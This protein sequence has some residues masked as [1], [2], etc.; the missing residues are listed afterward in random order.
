[1]TIK[2]LKDLNI[3]KGRFYKATYQKTIDGYTKTTTT[4]A[5]F[6]DYY[7]TKEAVA[8]G[9][10]PNPAKSNP[11]VKVII[12]DILTLN[13]N[14]NNYLVHLQSTPNGKTTTTYQDPN[15]NTIDKDT[16]YKQ[17]NTKP[18]APSSFH[19][20]KLQDLLNLE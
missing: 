17:T 15:G 20:V 12:K 18:S 4:T 1:M 9:R 5:R 19:N 10:K 16:Y 13:T 6:V 14:T 7:K 3:K 8:N 11:N 2:Q